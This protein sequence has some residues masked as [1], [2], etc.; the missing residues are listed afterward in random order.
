MVLLDVGCGNAPMGTVNV[1]V[2]FGQHRPDLPEV[3]VSTN[4]PNP[5]KASAAFLPFRDNSFK[6]VFS[7][8]MLEHVPNPTKCLLEMVRVASKEVKFIVPHRYFKGGFLRG[9][10]KTHK[11]N[12]FDT[13]NTSSWLKRLNLSFAI[14]KVEYKPY[15]Y[16]VLP[17]IQLPYLIHVKLMLKK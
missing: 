12:M 9:H 16:R 17:I 10:P 5:V 6:N 4:A 3:F 15:P 2:N 8:A 7:Q 11:Y 14:T 13:K 1:D